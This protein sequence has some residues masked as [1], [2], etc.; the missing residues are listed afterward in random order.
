MVACLLAASALVAHADPVAPKPPA[1]F[2]ALSWD[3]PIP[4]GGLPL[5]VRV[6]GK[7]GTVELFGRERSIP[8]TFTGAG[9]LVFT[10]M[11]ERDGEPVAV[12]AAKARIPDGVTRALLVFRL[13]PSRGPADLPYLV[14]VID[15]GYAV[16]PGQTV[17]FMNW[18]QLTLGGLLGEKTFTVDPGKEQVVTASLPE[19]DHLLPFKLARRDASGAWRRLRSTGLPMHAGLRVLVF[20]V[21]D[22]LRP[23]RSEMVL[24]RDVAPVETDA[25]PAPGI[26]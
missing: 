12:P 6:N 24:I 20:L 15:D 25:P 23:G 17:R 2:S 22:P 18:S 1:V 9:E 14:T 10:Q 21:D 26:P 3:L 13:N 11:I 4:E 19:P 8:Q 7:A 5:N 16:F